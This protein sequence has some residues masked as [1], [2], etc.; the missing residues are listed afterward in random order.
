[1]TH[2]IAFVVPTKDRVKDLRIMLSSLAVQTRIPEQIIIVDGSNPPIKFLCEEFTDLPIEYIRE[3]PPSLSRQRNAGIAKLSNDI[4]LAGYLDDDLELEKDA[5]EKMLDF[6]DRAETSYGGAAFSITNIDSPSGTKIKKWFG[7]DST[8]QGKVLPSG[9]VSMLGN[10]DV[11]TDVDWLCGGVTIWRRKIVDTYPYDEWFQ[12][13]GFLEDVDFS[14][15]VRENFKLALVAEA[16]VLHHQHP[17]LPD[18]YYLLGKWQIV[19]RHYFVRKYSHRGLS[20]FRAWLSSLSV[21]L[22]NIFK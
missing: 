16:K 13:T 4:T 3:F 14:F 20:I 8:E 12:G 11:T 9:W 10:T 21:I 19:N 18:R 6:W 2:K 1:M 17:I 22:L 5:V 15:N 7:L